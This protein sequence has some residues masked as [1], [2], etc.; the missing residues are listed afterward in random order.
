[1]PCR[2]ADDPEGLKASRYL[3]PLS[4]LNSFPTPVWERTAAKRCLPPRAE[5]PPFN[6]RTP[7]TEFPKKPK[8]YSYGSLIA[9]Q[10]CGKNPALAEQPR[11]KLQRA[12]A[13][14]PP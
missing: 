13:P 2:G 4:R 7:E 9:S 12:N 11:G 10:R 3:S 1:M 6:A 8:G 5:T 14:T